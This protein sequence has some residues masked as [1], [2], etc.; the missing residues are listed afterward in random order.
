MN[1]LVSKEYLDITDDGDEKPIN[2]PSQKDIEKKSEMLKC[3]IVG[4]QIKLE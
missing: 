1:E 4:L 2:Y 3:D